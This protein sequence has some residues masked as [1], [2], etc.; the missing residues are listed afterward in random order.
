MRAA[1]LLPRFL[2][3]SLLLAA[4]VA[5]GL[6]AACGDDDTP[7]EAGTGTGAEGEDDETTV[8]QG[9]PL[10][11]DREVLTASTWVLRVGGG[12]DGEVPM[13]DGWP[14]TITF[15]DDGT[16]GGTA[17]CNGYGG[18]YSIDGS[19]LTLGEMASTE[20]GC[21]PETIL[22]SEAAFIAALLDVDGINL[23]GG[24]PAELALSGPATELIFAPTEPAPTG[25]FVGQ[26]W[27]LETL[28]T[29]G[30]EMPA[31]G[32]PATLLLVADGTFSGSTGCRGLSGRYVVSGNEVFF[33]EMA[34]DGDCPT[35]L[36]D[37][38]SLV[39]TVLGDGFV[40]T[41][42]GGALTVTSAGE[43][44]LR[45]RMV[46]DED[47]AVETG[48]PVLSDVELLDGIEWTFVG[49]DSPDGPIADPATVDPDAAI[50][51]VFLVD[52]G[53][54]YEGTVICNRYG[55]PA[56]LGDGLL[57]FT[58]G[59]PGS[60]EEGCGDGLDAIAAAYLTALPFMNEGG[61]EDDGQALVINGNDIELL[62]ERTD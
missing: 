37:Q 18:S 46:T 12:P 58:L 56:E 29:G 33:N 31:E 53:G 38:D 16:F 42:D 36:F 1:R 35:S 27:L 39:V 59:V 41:V 4:L 15:N 62:F 54:Q 60:D 52:E 45:Y 55:G 13:V 19:Q 20:M 50:T 7:I 44:S 57:S 48:T 6:L 3:R 10:D 26:Q 11:I 23:S 24:D 51:L 22:E 25:E 30:E 43:E 8:D 9:E 40:P 28:V 14:I 34:A 47:L 49:G 17:A 61:V 5:L 2:L 32:E 21:E